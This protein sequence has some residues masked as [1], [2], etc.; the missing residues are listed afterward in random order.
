MNNQE[1]MSK[2]KLVIEDILDISIDNF[3]RENTAEDFDGWDSLAHITI[4]ACMEKE[5]KVRF[6]LKEV[7]KLRNVGEFADLVHSKV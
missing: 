7:Q 6:S 4:I 2:M 3:Q 5:F 1:I